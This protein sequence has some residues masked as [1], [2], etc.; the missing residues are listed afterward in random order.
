MNKI[1]EHANCHRERSRRSAISRRT[2]AELNK[3]Q[4]DASPRSLLLGQKKNKNKKRKP[5]SGWLPEEG[6]EHMWLCPYPE[7]RKRKIYRSILTR[8]RLGSVLC[9]AAGTEKPQPAGSVRRAYHTTAR[10]VRCL[11]ENEEEARATKRSCT[12]IETRLQFSTASPWP[13]APS[14]AIQQLQTEGT[15]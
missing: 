3:R 11:V 14:S 10:F 1:T 7:P 4:R 9:G 15:R 6:N 2:R 13:W 8:T 5:V 12:C